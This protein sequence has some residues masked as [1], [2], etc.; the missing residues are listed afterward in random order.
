MPDN[1]AHWI[2]DVESY[3]TTLTTRHVTS[4]GLRFTY[5][6]SVESENLSE[7]AGR[8]VMFLALHQNSYA[9]NGQENTR[10]SS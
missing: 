6:P 2:A 7:A 9:Q 3:D 1:P 10:L 8:R 4:P 5:S